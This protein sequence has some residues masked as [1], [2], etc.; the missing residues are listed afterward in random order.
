M[1]EDDPAEPAWKGYRLAQARQL[2]VRVDE[3]L[4]GSI[5]CQME[6]IQD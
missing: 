5:L 3:R 6:I 2:A 4:L 1:L